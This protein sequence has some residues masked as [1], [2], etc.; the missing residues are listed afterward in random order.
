MPGM[1]AHVRQR[2]STAFQQSPQVYWRHVRQK[3]KV[4]WNASSWCATAASS[5]SLRAS[6]M[7]SEND[8]SSERTK[9]FIPLLSVRTLPIRDRRGAADSKVYRVPHRSQNDSVRISVKC[10]PRNHVCSARPAP[11][12]QGQSIARGPTHTRDRRTPADRRSS[13]ET[14]QIGILWYGR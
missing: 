5:C 10:R 3:L 4:W 8:E 12:E 13:R 9:F 11:P 14:G 2:P 1:G 7:A 6:A